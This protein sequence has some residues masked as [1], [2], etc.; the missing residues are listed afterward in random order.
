[1]NKVD[2]SRLVELEYWLEG[3]AGTSAITPAVEKDSL[4]FWFFVNIFTFLFGMGVITLTAQ[5]FINPKHP[6]HTQLPVWGNNFVWMGLLGI[7]WFLLRQIEVGFLGARIW[8]IVGFVWII[9]LLYLIIRYFVV[10]F[11]L[12][13]A[14]YKKNKQHIK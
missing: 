6:I 1:M 5:K 14:F 3:V 2:W 8:L 12:E 13:Y 4:F 9:I 10:Y 7:I 11:P